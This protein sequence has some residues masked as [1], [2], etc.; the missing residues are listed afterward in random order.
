M[1][2]NL[3]IN[4]RRLAMLY[5]AMFIRGMAWIQVITFTNVN[6][7]SLVFLLHVRPYTNNFTN[8]LN[9]FNEFV[10]LIISY[11]VMTINGVSTDP[12]MNTSIG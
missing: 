2:S 9:I 7:L 11:Y 3:F 10:S 8:I 6:L 4:F 5:M 1:F 12:D